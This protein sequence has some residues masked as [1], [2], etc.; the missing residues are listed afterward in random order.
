MQLGQVQSG[1]MLFNTFVKSLIEV[2]VLSSPAGLNSGVPS[3][4]MSIVTFEG[5]IPL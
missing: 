1:S 3:L 4:P 5:Y 2:E